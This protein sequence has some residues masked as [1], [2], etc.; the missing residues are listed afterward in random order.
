M[1]LS[2]KTRY[3]LRILLQIAIETE[4]T[5]A[6]K[7]RIIAAKQEISEAYLEQIMIPL[8]TAGLVSTTR[9]CNGGYS[10]SKSPEEIT[11]LDIMELFEGKIEFAQCVKDGRRCTRLD[12]CP[13]TKIWEKLSRGLEVEAAK[14]TLSSILDDMKNKET[15]EYVI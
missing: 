1:Q 12:F 11:V 5:S 13:T 3:S 14:I 9:G 10:L 4:S 2:T 6:V 8:K 15:Q 7:G